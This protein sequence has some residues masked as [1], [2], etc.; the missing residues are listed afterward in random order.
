MRL[1]V[2]LAKSGLAA[3]R[4]NAQFLIGEGAVIVAGTTVSKPSLEIDEEA[5]PKIEVRG[6]CPFVSVGGMK[7][8]SALERFGFSPSGLICVD[9]GSST[10]GFTDCLLQNGAAKVY[11]VDSGTSQ[12]HPRLRDDARVVVMENTNARY[13]TKE[14]LG[15]PVSLAVCDVSFISQR[16]IIPAVG[17]LLGDGGAFITLIKPQFE[18]DPARVNK[19][20]GIVTDPRHRAEA[21]ASVA[22][23]ASRAGLYMRGI[24]VSPVSGGALSDAKKKAR[25]NREYVAIFDKNDGASFSEKDIRDFITNENSIDIAVR[26]KGQ[27]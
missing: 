24:A 14:A 7:L 15:D 4:S 9:I 13:L 21:V 18:L 8:A 26:H 19:G 5:P 2:Y 6:V 23:A 11:A 16:L 12:L 17:E 1:D 25:G 3:S 27:R 20:R 22:R 10:G